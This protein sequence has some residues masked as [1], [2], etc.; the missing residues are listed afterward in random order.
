M[1]TELS[2]R[3]RR[4]LDALDQVRGPQQAEAV[5]ISHQRRDVGSCLCGWAELGKSHAGH[6][7]AKLR[8]AG[9]LV[10]V[11]SA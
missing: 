7:V 9:L 2:P 5:L 11:R 3:A 4:E 6:Q 8:E 1:T 10:Q